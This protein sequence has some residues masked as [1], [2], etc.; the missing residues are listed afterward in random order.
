MHR[1]RSFYLSGVRHYGTVRIARWRGHGGLLAGR[2]QT[3]SSAA[4][5]HPITPE[6]ALVVLYA[7][8]GSREA[9]A[10][11]RMLRGWNLR[12]TDT[13]AT[14]T[15]FNSGPDESGLSD[16]GTPPVAAGDRAAKVGPEAIPGVSARALTL[17]RQGDPTTQILAAAEEISADLIVLGA[18]GMSRVRRLLIGSVAVS[19][20]QH[21]SCSVLVVRR[22]IRPIRSIVVATDGSEPARAAIQALVTLPFAKSAS[23]SILLVL[24]PPEF[25]LFGHHPDV[26]VRLQHLRAEAWQRQ[27]EAAESVCTE[28]SDRLA[29]AG[30]Q[31]TWEVVEGDAAQ[32]IIAAARRSVDLVV[33]GSRGRSALVGILLGSVSHA[34]LVKSRCSVLIARS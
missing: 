11:R 24:P 26:Y 34:V 9:E 21:A 5:A 3:A 18:K 25:E 6:E 20:A 12:P 27:R 30:V 23:C 10:V 2:V 33:V 8:D 17:E 28:A 14:I 22:P 15:V 1:F 29:R 4:R 19:V 16:G 13:L 31:A 32:Q 7:T